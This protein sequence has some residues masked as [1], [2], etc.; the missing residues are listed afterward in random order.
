MNSYQ[1]KTNFGIR[2]KQNIAEKLHNFIE[3]RGGNRNALVNEA[4]AEF[5]ENQVN[6]EVSEAV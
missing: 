3:L 6:K 2:V 5:L 4:I 1:F